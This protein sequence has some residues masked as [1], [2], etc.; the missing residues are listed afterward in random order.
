MGPAY[1]LLVGDSD[2]MGA[3]ALLRPPLDSRPLLVQLATDDVIVFA[4]N[5]RRVADALGLPA[6]AGGAELPTRALSVWPG[7]HDFL[8]EAVVRAEAAAFLA[9]HA[10]P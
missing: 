3:T 6:V 5:T 9:E 4:L 8:G 7:D 1:R 2:P 10:V